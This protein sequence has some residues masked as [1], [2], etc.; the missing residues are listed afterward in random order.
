MALL[1]TGKFDQGGERRA[2]AR[3]GSARRSAGVL[4]MVATGLVSI[5]WLTWR[6]LHLGA[7]PVEIS[8][9]AI[10]LVS[11]AAGLVVG[12]GMAR[13][14]R[15]RAVFESDPRESF[16]FVFA[17]ADIVGRTRA[18]DL[19]V[20]LAASYR[21]LFRSRP[22]LPDVVIAAALLD[23]PRRLLL[24]VSLT[25]A[26][27]IG[28]APMPLPPVW[29]IIAGIGA[30]VLMSVSHV[31]LGGGRIRFGDRIRWSSSALGEVCLGSDRDGLVPRRW[32]GTVAAVV[33]LNLAIGLRGMSDRWTH[34]LTPMTTDGRHVT[35]LI[36]IA[37]AA[38]GLFTLRTTAMPILENSHLVPRRTE[39]RTARQSA[40]G[41]A[42]TIGMIG[43]MAGILPGN[44]DATAGDSVPV[45]QI[46]DPDADD[47]AS[48]QG[49]LD[50]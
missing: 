1:K 38:G 48:D 2:V 28:V 21:T 32:A 33:M 37:V 29:A 24:V 10:E 23:G 5:A 13:A 30:L 18:T 31:L 50:G 11:I 6:V 7:H 4:T 26:L 16:R 19:R 39:E 44:F 12:V 42:V 35:M 34:G 43:L 47:V 20:D 22:K 40:L 15:P 8:V 3:P 27:L 17:V 49:A 45:E 9:F 25:I 14:P 46:S 36:A 41:A